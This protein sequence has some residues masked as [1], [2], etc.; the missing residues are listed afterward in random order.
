M[1]NNSIKIKNGLINFSC[2]MHLCNQSCC[3]PFAGISKELSNVDNRPFDEI[4][5]TP[6]DYKRIYENGYVNFI[7]EG[8]SEQTGKK[9]YKMALAPD[10]TCLALKNGLC[11]VNSIKPTL[12]KAFPFYID[13]FSGLCAI[14][15]DGFSNDYWTEI[16]NCTY[17][18]EAAKEMYEFWIDFYLSGKDTIYSF[19]EDGE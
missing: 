17:A 2:R 1:S 4:V 13:M 10:G 14:K 7:E 3:G 9:Y 19:S 5:L 12:C 6:N 18:I 11:S 8:Y 16:Q 15:C